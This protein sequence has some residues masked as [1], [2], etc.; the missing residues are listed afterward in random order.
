MSFA[1]TISLAFLAGYAVA[2]HHGGAPA[3]ASS[4]RSPGGDPPAW[5]GG[6]LGAPFMMQVA[7]ASFEPG[8]PALLAVIA[9]VYAAVAVA[10]L[11]PAIRAAQLRPAEALRVVG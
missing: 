5:A 2:G 1:A 3:A 11:L 9:A 7:G 4:H 10:T 6:S 8:I